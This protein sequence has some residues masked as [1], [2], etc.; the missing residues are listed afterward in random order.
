MYSSHELDYPSHMLYS[1]VFFG[2]YYCRMSS[3][4][5]DITR[6][7]TFGRAKNLGKGGY[8][9]VSHLASMN[10]LSGRP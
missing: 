1:P 4:S 3:D 5:S 8:H 2:P 6:L 7:L 9:I 10:K